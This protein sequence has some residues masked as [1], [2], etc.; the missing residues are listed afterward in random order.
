LGT[1]DKSASGDVSEPVL[2]GLVWPP[3]VPDSDIMWLDEPALTAASAPA[4]ATSTLS[5]APAAT[6]PAVADPFIPLTHVLSAD[7]AYEWHDAVA[8]VQQLVDQL[9]PDKTRPPLGSIPPID[10]IALGA[11][12]RLRAQLDPTRSDPVVADLGRLL[13]RLLQDKAV[14]ASLRLTAWQAASDLAAPMSLEELTRQ[15]AGWE[16]PGRLEKLAKLYE[17]GLAAAPVQAAAAVPLPM[18][19]Q[20]E[21][22]APNPVQEREEAK[23]SALRLRSTQIAAAAV[24][25]AAVCV[26]AAAV[27]VLRPIVQTSAAAP[28]VAAPRTIESPLTGTPIT[29]E[30]PVAAKIWTDIQLPPSK[31]GERVRPAT[32]VEAPAAR[33]ALRTGDRPEP[34]VA[35]SANHTEENVEGPPGGGPLYTADDR[36]VTEPVLINPY[37]PL[38]PKPG[39]TAEKLG[40]LELVVDTRGH[41]ESVHL[42]SPNNRYRERWW[43]FASKSWQFRPALKDGKPVR[44][45]KR[46]AL[47][48][49]N[50]AEPQ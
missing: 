38:L 19:V 34:N 21:A 28:S 12:G 32:N 36:S 46:I 23:P 11:S 40:V 45:L 50:L 26:I 43:V 2:D 24:L 48:D 4:V 25:I 9:I 8:L 14:P 10:A 44:F 35:T 27:M 15:L 17:R 7:V 16:R 30:A 49:L 5:T 47:T 1:V 29:V 33:G 13:H 39:V 20:V 18:P 6:A 22:Q 41:V 37:L 3:Q 42:K 31:I